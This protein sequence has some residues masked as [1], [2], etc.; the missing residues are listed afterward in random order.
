M[1]KNIFNYIIFLSILTLVLFSACRKDFDFQPSLGN[2]EFSKDTVFLDTVFANISSATYTLKVYNRSGNDIEI[3]TIRLENGLESNYR[4]NV[5]GAAGKKFENVPLLAKDSL[6]IFIEVTTPLEEVN[7]NEFLY[8]DV[9]EF[10]ST[11]ETQ[12]VALATLIKDAIFLY[13]KT[14]SDGT[15]ENLS[16]GL[17]EQGNEIQIEGFFLEED[18]LNFTNEK[19]YVIYGYAAV[20]NG[21]MVNFQAGTRVHFHENSGILVSPDASLQVNGALSTDQE[22]LENEVIFKGDRLG[23]IFD[24]VPGQWGAIWFAPGSVENEI[25]YLTIKNASIGLLVQGNGNYDLPNLAIKN[26]QVYNSL[27]FNLNASR[28]KINAENFVLGSAG[29]AS[30]FLN[31]GGDYNFNQSTIANYWQNGFRNAPSL[32]INN[33]LENSQGETMTSDLVNAS[34][35]NTIIDGNRSI[36]LQLQ[37]DEAALFQYKFENCILKFNDRF[38]EFQ[39]NPLYNFNNTDFFQFV[40]LNADASFQNSRE[41]DFSLTSNSVAIDNGNIEFAQIT[42]MDILGV[43]RS[44]LPDLGAYEYVPKN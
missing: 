12:T 17:D 43:N 30:I 6:F 22:L 40:L 20:P 5:D 38:N 28:A 3:P 21:S 31:L 7:K 4:L 36:E 26:S 14:S 9:I 18:E 8:T 19:P 11:N 27:N 1:R 16:L 23:S 44:K 29:S 37:K 25:N 2:L 13:P 34:F 42:I 24:N 15:T 41:N 10:G 32:I 35:T 39:A 33:F